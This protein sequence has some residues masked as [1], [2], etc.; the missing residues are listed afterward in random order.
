MHPTEIQ[1]KIEFI[2]NFAKASN[3]A[4]GSKVDANANVTNKDM[5]VMEAELFKSDTIQ[6]NRTLVKNKLTE[7]YGT[8]CAEY[9]EEDISDHLIYIH[10][11][12]SLKP[13]CVSISLYPYLLEGTKVL[14]GTS[15]APQNLR[16]FCGTFCNLVYQVASNFA[17]AV[18][19]VEFLL[20]FDYFA[21][22]TYGRD[23]LDTHRAEIAQE[24]QG[25][26]YTMNQPAAARGNQSVFWNISVFDKH[27]FDSI[28]GEFY[29]PDGTQGDYE[30]VAYLQ[31]FFLDWFRK[32]RTR[33]LLTFPVVTAAYLVDKET[34]EPLDEVFVSSLAYQMS[35]G[36]SFF[37]YESD[38]ADSLASCCRL[39]NELQDNTFSYTLGAGG[40]STGSFQVITINL[41]R[42][43]QRAV[44]APTYD[45]YYTLPSVVERVHKY[46]SAYRALVQD[47][48]DAKLLPVY[49]AGF[50]S[51]DKQFGTIGINGAIEALEFMATP[52]EDYK[53]ELRIILSTIKEM[54][55]EAYQTYGFRF[56]TEFVPAENLGVKNA[57]WDKEDGLWV[58]RDCYNSYFFPVED[59]TL[60]VLDRLDAHSAEVSNYLDGGAACHINL[61][62]IPS[63]EQA[64]SLIRNAAKL[65][66]PYWT[67]NVLTTICKDCGYINPETHQH[68]TKCGS[69][70]I[71][72]ATRVIGYL[73]PISSFSEGRRNEAFRR[74]YM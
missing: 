58:P 13:Y 55:K 15:K 49:D 42:I 24:L 20:Y 44:N 35:Q 62:Q 4:D 22:K 70:N 25:V 63:F 5:A 74:H 28:F 8:R 50:I 68:C 3:A 23:Y 48:I 31:D 65:G 61:E 71:E 40:V 9:F 57:K 72:Y 19:T 2:Q 6:I 1:K 38:S 41:N 67:T 52:K 43:T 32:E 11:E 29:F 47:Y 17:G 69:K 56:N 59:T 60:T 39:R 12:T 16:S 27:Y 53:S 10:D 66:V 64:L 37:H 30:S 36:L 51:L 21:R 54:N 73:K 14:G 46:L 34:R 45:Y 33:E 18:A 7:M 26:V